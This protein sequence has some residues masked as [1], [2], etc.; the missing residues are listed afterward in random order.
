MMSKYNQWQEYLSYQVTN[1][2]SEIQFSFICLVQDL[3][4]F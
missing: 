4:T 1:S 3:V 2:Y